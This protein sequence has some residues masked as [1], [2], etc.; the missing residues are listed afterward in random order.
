MRQRGAWYFG[1]RGPC[2]EVVTRCQPGQRSRECSREVPA[3][4]ALVISPFLRQYSSLSHVLIS[5]LLGRLLFFLSTSALRC[6]PIRQ[7]P[8]SLES[9]T[10]SG[11]S[12]PRPRPHLRS[13]ALYCAGITV[14]LVQGPACDQADSRRSRGRPISVTPD[15]A[16]IGLP[17]LV[18]GKQRVGSVLVEFDIDSQPRVDPSSGAP[19]HLP[20][21]LKAPFD[22][23]RICGTCSMKSGSLC[24]AGP[25]SVKRVDLLSPLSRPLLAG[26]PQNIEIES[27]PVFWTPSSVQVKSTRT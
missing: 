18:L 15:G 17:H 5:L 11:M 3:C 7:L 6:V 23:S 4:I 22:S 8:G 25:P 20:C 24:L 26:P 21:S 19:P 9:A 2:N 14:R 16:R 27:E 10:L 13:A 12:A 1:A